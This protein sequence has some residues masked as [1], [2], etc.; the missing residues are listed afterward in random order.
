M[1]AVLTR[2][3]E[4]R[5][6]SLRRSKLSWMWEQW[7]VNKQA[8]QQNKHSQRDISKGLPENSPQ[9]KEIERD[10]KHKNEIYTG[11]PCFNV[12][13]FTV[14]HRYY[15]FYKLKICDNPAS[16]KSSKSTCSLH[17]SVSHFCN[18]CKIS[19]FFVIIICITV[20]CSQW[21]LILLSQKWLQFVEGSD[22]G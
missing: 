21:S 19:S 6:P 11:I 5:H 8:K 16:S 9:Q 20:N 18:S 14:L 12:L 2:S 15:I 7:E 4:A 22:D 17:I 13:S 10:R 1:H 3:R